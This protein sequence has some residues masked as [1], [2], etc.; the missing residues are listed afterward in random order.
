MEADLEMFMQWEPV[1]PFEEML[2]EALEM[3]TLWKAEE[4]YRGRDL[5]WFLDGRA[6]RVGVR[7]KRTLVMDLEWR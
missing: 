3:D 1:R 6:I 5:E 2:A 7:T 4:D